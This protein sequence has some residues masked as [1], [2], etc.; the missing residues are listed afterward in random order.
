M[1]RSG[2]SPTAAQWQKIA[3]LLPKS[4]KN[5]KGGRTWIENRRRAAPKESV[6]S[7]RSA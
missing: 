5:R 6:H 7:R 2:P 3:P 4:R 1:A